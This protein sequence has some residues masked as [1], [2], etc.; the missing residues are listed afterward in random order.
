[1]GGSESPVEVTAEDLPEGVTAATV[2]VAAGKPVATLTLEA[3][4]QAKPSQSP[5]RLVAKTGTDNSGRPVLPVVHLP[6]PA[7]VRRV[8]DALMLSVTPASP[9][10]PKKAPADKKTP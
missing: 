3:N 7:P 5:I 9:P 6:G 10:P 8:T 4:A 2:T 1:M